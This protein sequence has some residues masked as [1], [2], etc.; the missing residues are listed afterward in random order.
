MKV[1]IDGRFYEKDDA[2]ISVFD[3]GLLYGDGVFEGIRAYNGRVFMLK[4]HVKRLFESAKAVMI[5]PVWTREKTEHLIVETVKKNNLRDAYIRVLITRGTGDLGLDMR[6]CKKPSLIIIADTIEL[7]PE[8]FY[9]KGLKVITSSIRKLGPDQLNPNIKSLNYLVNVLA[10]AE[11]SRAGCQEALL[12]NP[13]GFVAECSGDNIF[14]VYEGKAITTPAWA[15]IL[16][17]ITRAV[18]I[19]LLRN[20][21][22]IEVVEDVFTTCLPYKSDEVFLTGSGAEIIPVIEI[23]GRTIGQGKAGPLTTKLIRA[24]REYTKKTGTPVYEEVNTR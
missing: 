7:Y 19:D 11:A 4:E 8:E 6:K 13:Q 9:T 15:G 18:V 22:N 10:R 1:Y 3:H 20:Q 24:F 5:E 23:D 17:G 21:L 14:C 12:L 2:K 16:I